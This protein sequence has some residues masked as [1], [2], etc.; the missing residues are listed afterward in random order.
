MDLRVVL[1][2]LRAGEDHA[3]MLVSGKVLIIECA[4]ITDDDTPALVFDPSPTGRAAI[5]AVDHRQI[6]GLIRN[7]LVQIGFQHKLRLLPIHFGHNPPQFPHP[8]LNLYLQ[9]WA[10]VPTAVLNS[11]MTN[12]R[13]HGFHDSKSI[14]SRHFWVNINQL[15][16]NLR[17]R[18]DLAVHDTHQTLEERV[19]HQL[20]R[21]RHPCFI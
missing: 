13:Q 4:K 17:Y 21:Q 18:T 14:F 6:S 20:F 10:Q 1:V 16:L 9:E 12:Q 15:S 8:H 3:D 5:V 7:L 11:S 2:L 19:M